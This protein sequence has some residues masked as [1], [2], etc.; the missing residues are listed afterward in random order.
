M[1]I[2]TAMGTDNDVEKAGSGWL[3]VEGG[4]VGGKWETALTVSRIK[5]EISWGVGYFSKGL[6]SHNIH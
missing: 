1:H 6:E 4:K 2:C 5:K 3:G